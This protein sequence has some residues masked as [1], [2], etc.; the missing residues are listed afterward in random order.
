MMSSS[1]AGISTEDSKDEPIQW[2]QSTSNHIGSYLHFGNVLFADSASSKF[3]VAHRFEEA[4]IPSPPAPAPHPVDS[5]ELYE[6]VVAALTAQHYEQAAALLAEHIHLLLEIF[7]GTQLRHLMVRMEAELAPPNADLLYSEATLMLRAGH[8]ESAIVQLQQ[9]QVLYWKAKRQVQ[10]IRCT[11]DIARSYF[12]QVNYQMAIHYLTDEAKPLLDQSTQ[13]PAVVRADYL[14]QMANLATDTGHL[15]ASTEYARQALDYYIRSG[16]LPGQFRS[17]LR[18]ARNDMQ[19]GNYLEAQSRLQLI[20]QYFHIG[21]LGAPSEGLLLN[22]EIHLRWYQHQLDAALRL[23]QLY[24]KLADHEQLPYAQVYAR[25]LSAN[26]YR[27][28]HDYIRAKEWYD[29]TERLLNKLE[30][31]FYQPWLDAQRAWLFILQGELAQAEVHCA[32]ALLTTDWGQQMSF[33]VEKA[34]IH[35]LQGQIEHAEN[36]LQQSL[37]FY[38]NSGDRLASCAIRIYLAYAAIQ[39]HD[40]N[41]LLGH[42]EASF[43]PMAELQIDALPYWWHPEVVA[44][45]CCQAIVADL[46]PMMVKGIITKRLGQHSAP[47]LTKLLDADDLDIRNQAQLLLNTVTGQTVTLLEHLEECPAKQVLLE[48]LGKGYLLVDGYSRLEAE[49]TTAKLRRSPN[50]TLMAVFVLHTR[51]VK[52]TVIAKRLGCSIENVRNYITRIYQQ[53]GL[54]MKGFRSREERRQRLVAIARERGYIL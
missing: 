37:I 49:L 7:P 5:A 42:L 29:E 23:T 46:H 10:A 12:N 32:Q 11:V 33:Q 53:F 36:L 52:R 14:L 44:E 50:V 35:L 2:V 45:V 18:I 20:R 39:R 28:K 31:Y 24:L 38:E 34:V 8:F 41:S 30:F 6:Q 21:K 3:T 40:S 43:V 51:N 22:A 47:A 25:I 19:C 16:N 27:D 1:P 26:L 54:P 9:A 4:N 15:E 13:V 17:Q 48:L